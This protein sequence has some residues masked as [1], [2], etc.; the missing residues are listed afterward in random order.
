MSVSA[1]LVILLA[2]I[3]LL[4]VTVATAIIYGKKIRKRQAARRQ[5]TER[6]IK[7]SA[8]LLSIPKPV[9]NPDSL[10]TRAVAQPLPPRGWI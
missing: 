8:P 9:A 5:D 3:G 6:G 10:S 7:I 4:L 1:A 2:A